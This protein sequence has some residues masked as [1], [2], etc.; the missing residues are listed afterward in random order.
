MSKIHALWWL[1]RLG[2]WARGAIY[3]AIGWLAVA[4]AL[5]GTRPPSLRGALSTTTE[6]P[7]GL[8]AMLSIALG[9][10]GYAF[11]RC[12]QA[13]LDLHGVGT[14]LKGL[15]KRAGMLISALL[16]TGIGMVAAAVVA[17][18]GVLA[19]SHG[20]MAERWAALLL[21]WPL[22]RWLIAVVGIGAIGLGMAQ[23]AKLRGTAF[24][25]IWASQRTM[26]FIRPLG[27]VGLVAKGIVIR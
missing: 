18:W 23:L 13:V 15:A 8:A 11:W 7:L 16:H 5:T 1:A 2:Y 9:L 17:D 27:T 26:H 12:I 24:R 14:D 20:P 3:L 10:F 4:A 25:D 21:D 22:G 6:Q 19:G